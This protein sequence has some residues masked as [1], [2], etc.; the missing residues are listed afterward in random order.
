LPLLL[1]TYHTHS[2]SD[3]TQVAN[4][5]FLSLQEEKLLTPQEIIEKFTK[6]KEL[7]LPKASKEKYDP[8]A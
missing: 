1:S 5:N 8:V 7:L 6:A 2:F 3:S 4:D